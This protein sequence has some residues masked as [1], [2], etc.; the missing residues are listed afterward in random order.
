MV[1]VGG[2]A[3]AMWSC[4]LLLAGAMYS[5]ALQVGLLGG[6]G[7]L[8][9]GQL[10]L[11]SVALQMGLRGRGREVGVCCVCI[12]ADRR[13][14]QRKAVARLGVE[15]AA[16]GCGPC[17]AEDLWQMLS[18]LF[19]PC[20]RGAAAP[21]CTG[22]PDSL[23]CSCCCPPLQASCALELQDMPSSVAILSRCAPDE[24]NGNLTLATYRWGGS[25]CGR[26]LT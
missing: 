4:A 20:C 5:V 8:V 2:A 21:A 12:A 7:V 25:C 16:G 19:I 14:W 18:S 17:A 10:L 1:M 9:W 3:C 22:K 11:Y 13:R 24:A 23:P 6:G 26:V 15:C